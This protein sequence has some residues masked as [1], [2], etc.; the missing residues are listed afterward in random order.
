MIYRLAHNI[1]DENHSNYNSRQEILDCSEPILFDGIY[2]NVYEN[3]DVLIGKSG[4]L[5]VMGD[6][7]GKD[8]VFDL[9]N[10]PLLEKYCSWTELYELTSN[11]DFKLGWHTWSHPDLTKLNKHQIMRELKAPFETELFAYPYGR[12]NDLV[13]E[14]VKEAGYKYAYSVTQ[15]S[16]NEHEK[17]YNFKIYRD[18]I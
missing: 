5:F 13:I 7:V 4:I 11:F 1:G 8:N 17:D 15:G 10:V 6:Y 16:R 3:R 14:C 2:R 9:P 12:F 18:Y